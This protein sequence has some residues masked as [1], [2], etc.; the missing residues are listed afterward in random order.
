MP[1]FCP[2]RLLSAAL[3]YH[4]RVLDIRAILVLQLIFLSLHLSTLWQVS[5]TIFLTDLL[6]TYKKHIACLELDRVSVFES[7]LT[8]V[9][10]L[11]Q[12]V[13]HVVKKLIVTKFL[14]CYL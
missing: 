2:L 1:A 14:C 3:R 6:F 11:R 7:V 5:I 8:D 10:P 9:P 12:G 13:M 4:F